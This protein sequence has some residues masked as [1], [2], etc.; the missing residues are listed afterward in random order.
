MGASFDEAAVVFSVE[1]A[2]VSDVTVVVP[3]GVGNT[4][5]PEVVFSGI[6]TTE[7]VFS[8]PLYYVPQKNTSGQE[9]FLKV[10]DSHLLL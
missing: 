7:V 1:A 5:I 6:T 3:S 2:V 4:D 8:V 9:V 10:F